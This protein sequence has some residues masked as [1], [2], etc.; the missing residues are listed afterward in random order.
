MILTECTGTIL[1]ISALIC[2]MTFSVPVVA[3]VIREILRSSSTSDTVSEQDCILKIDGVRYNLTDWAK[4]HPGGVKI[5]HKFHNKDAS[6]A[7]HAAG[8]SDSAY[9]ML[10]GGSVFNIVDDDDENTNQ[11]TNSNPQPPLFNFAP[12]SFSVS[13]NGNN[14]ISEP[15][16][17][18]SGTT[19]TAAAGTNEAEF[20][21]D[22]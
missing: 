21:P 22:L 3:M 6:A 2:A 17:Q 18:F 16:G 9:A 10:Q 1:S 4:A 7:F 11:V 5:L 20:D 14:G 12:A 8:H 19:A 13:N 15:S